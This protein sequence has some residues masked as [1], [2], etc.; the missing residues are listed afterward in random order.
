M[1]KL[2]LAILMALTLS[3]AYSQNMPTQTVRGTIKDADI[4]PPPDWC[5]NYGGRNRSCNGYY[6]GP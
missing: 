3:S 1:K 6:C 4:K 5:N 2:A